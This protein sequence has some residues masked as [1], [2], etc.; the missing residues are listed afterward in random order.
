[1]LFRDS[2]YKA[3]EQGFTGIGRAATLLL[4]PAAVFST[5]KP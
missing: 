5:E 3:V 4:N 1:L 2:R